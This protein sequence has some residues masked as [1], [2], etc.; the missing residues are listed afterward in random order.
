MVTK[1][2]AIWGFMGSGKTSVAKVLAQKLG[3]E[4]VD[5]D[6]VIAQ[7]FGK[8]I[9]KIFA[10]DGEIAFRRAESEL[11]NELLQ[12]QR[13]VI[14]TGGGM[15][16]IPENLASLRLKA[17]NFYLRVPTDVLYERLAMIHDRPLLEGFADRYWRIATL[18]SQR[19]RFYTQAQFI[20][21][22]GRQTPEQI[23]EQIFAWVRA[24]E[25]EDESV[26][27]DLSERSYNVLV[28]NDLLSRIE[29]FVEAGKLQHPF[30]V[31]YDESVESFGKILC[32]RLSKLGKTEGKGVP[33][34]ETSK[35]IEQAISLWHWLAQMAMPRNGTL[36]AVGGGVLGDLVG[37][38]AATYM[39]G[40][41]YVQV[42]TTLL[43][44]VDSAIGGKTAIDLPHAKNLVG[45]FH[46]PTLVVSDLETLKTMPD[47]A[48]IAGL[49]EVVKYGVIADPALLRYLRE[50]ANLILRRQPFA[51]RAIIAR[52]VSVKAN[53][54]ALDEYE[55]T[56]LRMILNYGHTFGHAL[57]AATNFQLLH[58][59]AVAI[60][61]TA[62]AYLAWR[63]GWCDR[64]VLDEQ[65]E[66]LRSLE[67]PTKLKEVSEP[68]FEP[69]IATLA[70]IMQRDKKRKGS[71]LRFALPKRFGETAT[72]D[73]PVP[74][75]ILAD[76]WMFVL[77]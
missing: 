6:E 53:I 52:S 1:P 65:I 38:V 41:A 20:V 73:F 14:A 19:E 28:G 49:A 61:M 39:R 40:V 57:E 17:L 29:R 34:G 51:L 48:F 69:D 75:D 55:K 43:A 56:G 60:G 36:F 59:E 21:H 70:E 37:F 13:I 63:I 67:L 44:M 3:Y 74:D 50:N 16:T 8:P 12:R 47:R 31:I 27:V 11:L 4:F 33:S 32:E 25:N 30:A 24:L 15:P 72:T 23:A 71:L 10:E 18:L 35:N 22:C 46:Q 26:T 54:V 62:E 42:P 58:G 2:I 66:I 45:A 7:R 9:T 77:R 5:T 76:A 64:E 68:I